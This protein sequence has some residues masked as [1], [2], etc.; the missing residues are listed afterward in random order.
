[1]KKIGNNWVDENNNKW[2]YDNYTEKEA[3]KYSESLSNCV[4]CRDCKYCLNCID[5]TN[6][7]HC[8]Y[9]VNC[10]DCTY[11]NDCTSCFGCLNCGYCTYCL[12]CVYCGRCVCC[13]SCTDCVG[14]TYFKF[15]PE[16][17]KSKPMGS[18]NDITRYYLYDDTIYVSCGCFWGNIDKFIL[19]IKDKHG[20]N[21]YAQDYKKQIEKVKKYWS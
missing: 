17:L 20:D 13:E 14:C 1:M 8:L 4:N 12:N 19:T 3:I 11:S 10:K 7:V 5:C 16:C 9:C 18:R 21:K 2:N 15:N 6:C